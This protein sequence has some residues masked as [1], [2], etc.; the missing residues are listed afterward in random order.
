M[1]NVLFSAVL[2]VLLAGIVILF[3]DAGTA[4]QRKSVNT[5]RYMQ[6][7]AEKASAAKPNPV[8]SFGNSATSDL[9][10]SP[11]PVYNRNDKVILS[12]Q[13]R[14]A[15]MA[16]INIYD[17]VGS[18]VFETTVALQRPDAVGYRVTVPWDCRNRMGRY[19]GNGTYLGVIRIFDSEQRPVARQTVHIGVAY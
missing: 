14:Y 12:C 18:L 4:G 2:L 11:N 17:A 13:T 16:I 7:E 6:S 1:K 10:V 19:V 3:A 9:T 5:A 15:G 8:S